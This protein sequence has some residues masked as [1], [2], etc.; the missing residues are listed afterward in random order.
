M[1]KKKYYLSVNVT[2]LCKRK[3]QKTTFTSKRRVDAA[4]R[5]SVHIINGTSSSFCTSLIIYRHKYC[6]SDKETLI[7]FKKLGPKKSKQI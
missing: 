1:A 3:C 7:S 6:E 4:V 5:E 2:T